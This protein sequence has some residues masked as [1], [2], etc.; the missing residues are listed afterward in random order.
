MTLPRMATEYAVQALRRRQREE[1]GAGPS[2]ETRAL[3]GDARTQRAAAIREWESKH[4]T[5]PSAHVFATDILPTLANVRAPERRA[6]TGL[7]RSYCGRILRGQYIPHPM[8]WDAIRA[9]A[10]IVRERI[11]D[12]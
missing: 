10:R 5:V 7:C 2:N 4:P 8:H 1:T 3:M 9:L 11:A 6:V 12:K